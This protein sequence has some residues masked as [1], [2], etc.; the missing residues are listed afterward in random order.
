MN[1]LGEWNILNEDDQIARL[2]SLRV[3]Y[4]GGRR[5]ELATKD[6]ERVWALV[7]KLGNKSL[8]AEMSGASR[9]PS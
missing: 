6:K 8:V 4:N 5:P 1:R 7:R 3:E 2:R 9:R